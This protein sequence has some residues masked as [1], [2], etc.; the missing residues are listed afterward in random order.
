ML[1]FA[2]GGT[3]MSLMGLSEL[4]PLAASGSAGIDPVTLLIRVRNYQRVLLLAQVFSGLWLFPFGW[5]VLRS[6]AAPR[7]LALSLMVGGCGY[8]MTFATAFAPAL[9]L[10]AA[11]RIVGTALGVTALVGEFGMCV[12][13]LVK[14]A[15]LRSAPEKDCRDPARQPL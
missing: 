4:L 13:L 10:N 12:W 5:L 11:V 14:G 8:V 15:A 2:A 7:L 9:N 1:I 3:A 6:Q